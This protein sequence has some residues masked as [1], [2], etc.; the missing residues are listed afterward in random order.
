MSPCAS[1]CGRRSAGRRGALRRRPR[2]RP[3]PRRDRVWHRVIP[4]MR[5]RRDRAGVNDASLRDS[6]VRHVGGG[7]TPHDPSCYERGLTGLRVGRPKLKT[8]R[9]HPGRTPLPPVQ[10]GVE[11]AAAGVAA[12][13]PARPE[14]AT[15]AEASP[16]KYPTRAARPAGRSPGDLAAQ[17]RLLVLEGDAAEVFPHRL[18]GDGGPRERRYA[19]RPE[20]LRGACGGPQ[21]RAALAVPVDLE[22]A[23]AAPREHERDPRASTGTARPSAPSSTAVR[24]ASTASSPTL[25]S[26]RSAPRPIAGR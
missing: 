4:F 5:V 9:S 21:G 8:S 11:P 26:C 17:A 3:T 18:L 20:Q 12:P 23:V 1:P 6:W 19:Q 2:P 16:R 13:R 10:T 7:R 14:R 24:A 15:D 25:T 22:L